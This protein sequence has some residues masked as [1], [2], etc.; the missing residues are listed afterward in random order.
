MATR[1]QQINLSDRKVD[2]SYNG[3]TEATFYD[4]IETQ[5][6]PAAWIQL[7]SNTDIVIKDGILTVTIAGVATQYDMFSKTI[8]E[9]IIQLRASGITAF[10]TTN[11]LS[12]VPVTL[13][14][15]FQSLD[16][17]NITLD[18]SPIYLGDF[19]TAL[20]SD[21]VEFTTTNP[22]YT[23]LSVFDDTGAVMNY[24]YIAA[25]KNLFIPDTGQAIV[26]YRLNEFLL[27]VNPLKLIATKA[28]LDYSKTNTINQYE[29]ALL[30]DQF[31][32]SFDLVYE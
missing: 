16:Y 20:I 19:N 8:I 13:V 6:Y 22:A 9:L 4:Q 32:G 23:V 25:T 30:L 12:L 7:P 28:L 27:Y 10:I 18:K 26:Q 31:L 5:R 24:N 15:N 17:L 14:E 1:L 3:L 29:K 2:T 21:L 11:S